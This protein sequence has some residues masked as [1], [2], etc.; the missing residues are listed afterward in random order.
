MGRLVPHWQHCFDVSW[1][2]IATLLLLASTA[3]CEMLLHNRTHHISEVNRMSGGD[4][5]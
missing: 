2:A 5:G 3:H 1:L 4:C